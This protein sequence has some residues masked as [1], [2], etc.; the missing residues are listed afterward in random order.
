MPLII[1]ENYRWDPAWREAKRL[2]AAGALG[3]LHRVS[4]RL[5]PG[6]RPGPRP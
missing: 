2:V 3:H 6:G 1:H 5:R 4:F